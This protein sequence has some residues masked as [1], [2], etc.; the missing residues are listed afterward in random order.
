MFI[1]CFSHNAFP[2]SCHADSPTH[3]NCFPSANALPTRCPKA[4]FSYYL[5]LCLTCQNENFLPVSVDVQLSASYHCCQ[6]LIILHGLPYR[7]IH[8][9]WFKQLLLKVWAHVDL[10]SSSVTTRQST[11]ELDSALA[12]PSVGCI[13]CHKNYLL[14]LISSVISIYDRLPSI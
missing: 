2:S 13:Y 8:T 14:L 4:I 12:A 11:S 3:F 6:G 7:I 10:R 1:F 9:F 5:R